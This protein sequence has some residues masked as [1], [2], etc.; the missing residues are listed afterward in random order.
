MPSIDTES[1]FKFLIACIKHSQAGK[2][3][4]TEVAK[5]CSIVTK[6]AAAKRYE[7][8]MKQHGIAPT[9][10]TG[11]GSG[12]KKEAKDPS[13]EAAKS[14]K[15]RKLDKVEDDVGDVDEPIKGEVKN[16]DATTTA[17]KSE[18]DKSDAAA[19]VKR[20][21]V[22]VEQQSSS[23]SS[24][25]GLGGVPVTAAVPAAAPPGT[26]SSVSSSSLAGATNSQNNDDDDDDEVLI[27]SATDRP[28]NNANVLGFGSGNT[29]SDDV[30]GDE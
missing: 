26:S 21:S 19:G 4:F 23:S 20:E 17:V 9:G 16:E 30:Q 11:G 8:L 27:V 25:L 15:K 7:R 18:L 24:G 6:G 29:S 22:K 10:N 28:D 13:K 14:R 3:D 2:V 5:E 1:Q 12:V